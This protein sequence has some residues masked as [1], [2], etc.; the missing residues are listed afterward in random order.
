MNFIKMHALGNDFVIIYGFEQKVSISRRQAQRIAH[1]NKGI[2]CDQILLVNKSDDGENCFDFQIFNQDGS[3]SDQCGN[4][5]RCVARLL[6]DLDYSKNN[7]I[8]L[9]TSK[10]EMVCT[11][12]QNLVSVQI[13]VPRFEPTEIPFSAE[14]RQKL[15]S[16]EVYGSPLEFFA[17]SLGNP[18]AVITVSDVDE[19][20]V[21]K[22]GSYIESH[23]RFPEKTNVGF[24]EIESGD[25]IRLRVFER[26]VGETYACGSGASAA[27]VAG[28][29]QGLLNE[30]VTVR[31]AEGELNVRWKGEGCPVILSGPATYVFRGE[32]NLN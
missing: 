16:I 14:S 29:C 9:N 22:I 7:E 2:G 5:A 11:I 4:G 31:M 17:L 1:R 20:N 23:P 18:H 26:G 25:L 3:E 6:H 32:L 10:D 30:D 13:G 24:M 28:C 8:V 27:A 15:Y 12:S 21:E 19:A